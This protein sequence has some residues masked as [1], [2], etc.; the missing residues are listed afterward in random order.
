MKAGSRNIVDVTLL[1]KKSF[2]QVSV[3]FG[4]FLT[5]LCPTSLTLLKLGGGAETACGVKMLCAAQKVLAQFF[6]NFMTFP[7]FYSSK[8]WCIF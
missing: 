1:I 8:S 5:T 2:T 3:Q 6:S 4:K 7:D